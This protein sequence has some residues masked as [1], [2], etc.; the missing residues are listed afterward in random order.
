MVEQSLDGGIVV[1]IHPDKRMLSFGPDIRMKGTANHLIGFIP[2]KAIQDSPPGKA[3]CSD[4][5]YLFHQNV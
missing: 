3:V 1:Y 5:Q 4:N 2:G